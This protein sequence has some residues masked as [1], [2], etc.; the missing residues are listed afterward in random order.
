MTDKYYCIYSGKRKPLDKVKRCPRGEVIGGCDC[1][2]FQVWVRQDDEHD[3]NN[4]KYDTI[5]V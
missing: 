1:C 3:L 4:Q 5:M 2:C